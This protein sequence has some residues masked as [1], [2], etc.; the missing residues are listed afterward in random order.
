MKVGILHLSDIH[1]ED[2]DDWIID[3]AQKIAQAVL[4][5]WEELNNIFVVVTGDI[6]N[7]GLPE[8]YEQAH[9]FFTTLRDY[10]HQQSGA[11]VSLIVA[12]G[13]HDC[14]FANGN[15][16]AK[17]RQSFI[18]TVVNAPSDVERG[19]SIFNGSGVCAFELASLS[20][21]RRRPRQHKARI[22]H[23]A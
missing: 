12:P 8:H 23:L 4:G 3:K 19:D 6:A 7:K 11:T 17:A 21:R 16:D 22:S 15:L 20:N 2:Q 1:I 10:L 14:N 9:E 18:N 5:T 13:N